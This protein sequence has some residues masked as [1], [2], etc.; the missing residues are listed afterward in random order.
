MMLLLTTPLLVSS[1][2]ALSVGAVPVDSAPDAC[3]PKV[4]NPDDPQ[5]SCF[6][7]PPTVDSAAPFGVIGSLLSGAPSGSKAFSYDWATCNPVVNLVCNQM[8]AAN[9]ST[10]RVSNDALVYQCRP[11]R[12]VSDAGLLCRILQFCER[13]LEERHVL[14]SDF[15]VVLCNGTCERIQGP[16]LDALSNGVLDTERVWRCRQ[17][18]DSDQLGQTIKPHNPPGPMPKNLPDYA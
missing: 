2:L 16:T 6:T 14:I 5:D 18:R 17:T 10:G 8:F 3:G 12:Y 7:K 4:Q 1:F 9:F 15:Q 13:V 11:S